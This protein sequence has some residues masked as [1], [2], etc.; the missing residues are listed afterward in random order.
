AA[1]LSH[2]LKNPVAAIRASAEV[3]QEGALDEP[4]QASRFVAR[5]REAS[6]RIEK[7]L[8]ELLSLAEVETRGPEHLDLV[9]I[10]SVIEQIL[11][12]HAQEVSRIEMR[13]DSSLPQVRGDRIW[14]TRAL[15]NLI[16]NA[17]VHS[18]EGSKVEVEVRGLSGEVV[19]KTTND[20]SLD[21]HVEKSL[22]RRFV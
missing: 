14:L 19:I 21:P 8:A 10:G 15:S 2:E 7:L 3:L 22:F 9:D 4:E 6:V 16:D 12:A 11:D 17:L 13:M 5:I 1:D 20:G 18:P